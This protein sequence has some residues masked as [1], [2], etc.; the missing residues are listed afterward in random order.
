MA[1]FLHLFAPGPDE[2]I[3]DVG[4]NSELWQAV[5]YRGPVVFLNIVWS[6][7]WPDLPPGCSFLQGDGRSLPFGD[8]EFGIVFSNSVIE[9]VGDLD[10]QRRF[11]SEIR[12]VGRRYWVQTPNRRFIVEPHLRFPGFQWLPAPVAHAVVATWPFSHHRRDGLT[13]DEA[14]DA[15]R[16]TRLLTVSEMRELFPDAALWRERAVGLTKSII[17]YRA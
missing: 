7:D 3:L 15:V 4:G 14:W 11:A 12:R 10:D 16:H 6:D 2:P 17:A 9:H 5:A 8:D 13:T 1:R